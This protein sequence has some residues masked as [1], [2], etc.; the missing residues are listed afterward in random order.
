MFVLLEHDGGNDPRHW[1][2]LVEMPGAEGLAT[3]RLDRNP[4]DADD[5]IPARHIE[6]HRRLYLDY[7]G[8]ISG[9]R[10]VVRRMDRGDAIVD[11]A[12]DRVILVLS[13]ERLSGRF[14]IAPSQAG[15]LVFRRVP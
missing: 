15:P 2:L 1:D 3:W 4:L 5:E 11:C 9:G 6:D 8:E 10:G 7:E 14:E 12:G 13:G